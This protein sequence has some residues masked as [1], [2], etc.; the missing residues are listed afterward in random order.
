MT[1]DNTRKEKN[2]LNICLISMTPYGG[3][4]SFLESIS[5]RLLKN[6]CDVTILF[7]SEDNIISLDGVKIHKYILNEHVKYDA[8]RTIYKIK[9]LLGTLVF[10]FKRKHTEDEILENNLY[11]SQ[12]KATLISKN[13]NPKL[14][15]SEYDCVISAEEVQCNYFLAYSVIAKKK[16]GYVHPD[17]NNVPYNKSMDKK[18]FMHLDYVCATSKANADSIK[19]AFPSLKDKIIGV[20]NPIDVASIIQKSNAPVNC[21]YD[22][23]L[24]NLVTVCRLDNKYKALDRL[25]LVAK[26]LKESGDKF[27]WRVIGTG[28]YEQT[29]KEFISNHSLQDC[30]IMLGE[31][32]NPIPWIKESDLFILQSYSE[33]YPMSVNEAL[34]VYTPVLVTNYPSSSEQVENNVTGYIVKNNF[35]AIYD[36]IH[37]VINNRNELSAIKNNLKNDDKTKFDNIDKLMNIVR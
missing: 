26:R 14:D 31:M 13:I 15:L 18:A 29:M 27:V 8:L 17:Y 1:A 24:V 37:Y 25:L 16:I 35:D 32:N 28:D 34:V 33:G 21:T 2:K 19:N 22:K 5:L 11:H 10:R 36:K 3:F 6:A 23:N 12:L 9:S 20:P 30:V 7:L 4:K